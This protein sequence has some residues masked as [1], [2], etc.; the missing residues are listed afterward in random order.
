MSCDVGKAMKGFGNEALSATSPKSQLILQTFRHF[1]YVTGNSPTLPLLHL[2]HSSFSKP[3]V[4]LPMSQLIL[5][6]FRYFTYVTSHSTTLPSLHLRHSSLSNPSIASPT[7]QLILQPFCPFTYV[8]GTSPASPVEPPMLI[9]GTD[10][11]ILNISIAE[12][13]PQK[14]VVW[15]Y[16]KH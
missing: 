12:R 8:T 5:E 13:L 6:L 16:V 9:S 14:S 2:H 15:S 7:S 1:I 11:L 10:E 4:A 3:S